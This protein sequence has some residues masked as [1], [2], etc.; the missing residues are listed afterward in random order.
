M[1]QLIGAILLQAVKDLEDHKF[2]SDAKEFF[3]SNWFEVLAE[4]LEM[5]P[6]S[7]REQVLAN[8]YQHLNIRAGYH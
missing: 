7:M 1:N 2:E 4:E 6:V 3:K 8:S 5:N